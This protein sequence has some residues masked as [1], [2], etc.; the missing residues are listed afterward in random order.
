MGYHGIT[1]FLYDESFFLQADRTNHMRMTE[2]FLPTLK[3]TPTD[4][5]VKSHQFML[6]SGMVRLLSAGIYSYLPMG[7]KVLK[8]IMHIIR[9]E[10]DDI[11]GQEVYLPA[12]NPIE[13]WE[14]T[15]RA[16]DF[17]DEMFKLED[18]KSRRLCLAPTHEEV[19]C[20]IARGEIRSYKELPQIWY[21]I[22][23]KFRDEPRPRS[24]VLRARQFLMKDS[25]S[26]DANQAGLDESYSKHATAYHNIFTR[27]GLNFFVVKASSG[28]MGGSASQEFMVES[29][30]GEDTVALCD[31]CNYAANAQVAQFEISKG[32]NSKYDALEEIHTPGKRTIEEVSGFLGLSVTHFIKTLLYVIDSEPTM[33]LIRGDYELNEDKLMA[34]FGAKFR[35]A[36]IDEI[37]QNTGANA[38][39]IGPVGIKDIPIYVDKSIIGQ[40]GFVSGANKDHYHIAGIDPG[41]HFQVEKEVDVALVKDGDLC[42]DCKSPL[43][44][45]NAIEVG[46]LFKLGTKYS[47][48]MGATFLDESGKQRPIV[49]GSYG[50]G[51]ERIAAAY[52]EQ[53]VD[54]YGN[55]WNPALT[56][57]QV[58]ILPINYKDKKIEET[59]DRLYK[60]LLD[61]DVSVLLD[62]RNLS[63]GFKFRDADLLGVPIQLILGEKN[64]SNGMVELKMRNDP[65]SSR[66][67]KF[68]TCVEDVLKLTSGEPD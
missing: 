7:W 1:R 35:P 50:I 10:M 24:G 51:V 29:E 32:E 61:E 22:Q 33:I 56:P 6:R 11:G 17:G 59:A 16:Q 54:Q 9:E 3:E 60:S 13:I 46:H 66:L 34:Q 5:V 8:N 38:G 15:G 52:M 65:D 23:N 12:V 2:A 28:L 45:V 37:K 19:I 43:R 20:S 67:L 26:L 40:S 53:N 18:R 21:Q 58:Q 68:E 47:D 57:Y 14:E 48:S 39:F 63:P 44:V 55:R 49:M 36:E 41:S 31:K 64:L 27:S 30:A 25:Y 4:A 62:D 42:I